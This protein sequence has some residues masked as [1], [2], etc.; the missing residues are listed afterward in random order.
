[1]GVFFFYFLQVDILQGINGNKSHFAILIAYLISHM[2]R[3][4]VYRP[5]FYRPAFPILELRINKTAIKREEGQNK[6]F[7]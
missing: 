5:C 7:Q 1:V 2:Y 3:I 4:N 6:F